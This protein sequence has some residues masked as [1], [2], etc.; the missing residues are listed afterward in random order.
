MTPTTLPAPVTPSQHDRYQRMLQ[1]ATAMLA[2]GGEDALQ[3]KEL[4]ER[5]AV[6]LAT[7]YRYF[8]SKDHLLLAISQS[9][10]ENALRRVRSETPQGTTVQERVANHLLREF[11]AAQRD[12]RLTTA[13]NRVLG[14]T[15]PEYAP[16]IL[17]TQQLHLQVI[18]HVAMAG[19][20]V[21]GELRRRLR[22]VIDVF[23]AAAGRWLAGVSSAAEARFEI[24][25]G[26]YLLREHPENAA[27]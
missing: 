3:M 1:A 19:G 7:L 24:R 20:P 2:G 8:P 22:I 10:Y 21:D 23:V 16:I 27:P 17:Q 26:C 11:R 15:R 9:R 12:Q 25:V 4:A 14:D 18:E 13:L 5:A 6:S